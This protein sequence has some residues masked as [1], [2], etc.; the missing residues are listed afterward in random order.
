MCGALHPVSFGAIFVLLPQHS[1]L[2]AS[3]GMINGSEPKRR[4]WLVCTSDRREFL[5]ADVPRAGM[6]RVHGHPRHNFFTAQNSL[7]SDLP[8][9]P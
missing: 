4:G 3:K 7:I 2:Q 8:S 5:R 9:R 1:V 6:S